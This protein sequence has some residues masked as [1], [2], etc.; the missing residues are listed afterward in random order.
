MATFLFK[1]EPS[2]YAYADLERE[3]RCVWQGVKNP[4]A[5]IHLRTV[6]AGDEVLVYHTGDEKAIVG[7]AKVTRGA[8]EDPAKPGVNDAGAP[9]FA[10]VDVSP[11]RAAKTPA[12]LA[13]IKADA[14]FKEIA[15][16]THSRLSVMPVPGAMEKALRAMAGL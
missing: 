9:K 1:T 2:D 10:V 7:L 12:T 14:R 13:A 5:L 11:A 8:Y 4:Q 6:A 16:V 3:G 15:L